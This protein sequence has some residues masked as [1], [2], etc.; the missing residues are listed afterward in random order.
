M[1]ERIP[2]DEAISEKLLLKKR[3]S[4]LSVPQQV[5]LK[6]FYGCDL[7]QTELEHW[8]MFQ[9]NVIYD[10][11]G[12]PVKIDPVPYFP[13]EY[14]QA[15]MIIGRRGG[16][17]DTFSTT[18]IAYE[19]CLGGHEDYKRASQI[20]VCFLIAQ[21][22]KLARQTLPLVRAT[23]ESSP[24]MGK[25]IGDSTADSLRLNNG[26]T[27]GVAPPN[28]KA[29]RGFAVPVVA[30]DEVGSWYKDS[31][32]ANP[33]FEVER[34]VK[35][36]QG[37]FPFRKRVGTTTPWTKEGLAWKYHQAGTEGIFLPDLQRFAYK[38]I[39]VLHASTAAMGNPLITRDW[40]AQERARDPEGFERESLARF[41]DSISG[42]ISPSVLKQAMLDEVGERAPAPEPMY[43][44]A[45]DPAFRRD[46]FAFT[47]V[48]T[49]PSIGLVQDVIRRWK[50]KP[51]EP[52]NPSTVLD[53]IVPLLAEYR[54]SLV[55]SD[56]YQL[57]S[58]QQLALE[59]GF[60]IEGV[61]FTSRSKARIFGSLSQLL[62]Q[63]RVKLLTKTPEALEQQAELL[64]LE[65]RNLPAGGVQIAAPQGR[66]DD[67]AC[68]LALAAYK[69]VW[70]LPAAV[71]ANKSAEPT[72]HERILAQIKSK[73][74]Q[75]GSLSNWD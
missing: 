7:N 59:R 14:E 34:T 50:A 63:A 68:V 72:I 10:E 9:R 3:F 26:L 52:L 13:Q 51:G 8:A 28:T 31:E 16:K 38:K 73:R 33:D 58:L 64:Q 25:M 24:L 54:V 44:A 27:I 47:I 40:L 46:A 6:V 29:I 55:Y 60:A 20:A 35:Y 71:K 45:L 5:A 61:D 49:D 41:V 17:T 48:H 66:H 70:L 62:N 37:Q 32:S 74:A 1:A 11:L 53:E 21:D 67:L 56:Q 57:E 39:L 22:L 42:F 69:A 65:K 4:E 2:F 15:W 23:L 36:A 19:A 43:V 18:I 12:Y 75:D 30:M